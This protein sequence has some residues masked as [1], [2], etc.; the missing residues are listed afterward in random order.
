[1]KLKQNSEEGLMELLQASVWQGKSGPSF[2]AKAHVDFHFRYRAEQGEL[3]TRNWKHKVSY[4]KSQYL[5]RTMPIVPK[6]PATTMLFRYIRGRMNG[7][8]IMGKKVLCHQS[9]ISRLTRSILAGPELPRSLQCSVTET[10][11]AARF[12]GVLESLL[13]LN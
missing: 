7:A 12:L 3:P 8:F 13:T 2:E 5:L 11:A 10:G 1:M 6:T 9:P 4:G